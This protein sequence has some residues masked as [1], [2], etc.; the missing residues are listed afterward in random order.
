MKRYDPSGDG[1]GITVAIHDALTGD[2]LG[3]VVSAV[4]G[5]YS[6]TWYDDTREVYAEAWVSDSY[7]GRS[8][9]YLPVAV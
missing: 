1:S 8:S 6:F 5:G 7:R 3:S 2:K 9:N 4:G